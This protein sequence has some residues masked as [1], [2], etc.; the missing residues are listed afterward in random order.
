MILDVLRRGVAQLTKIRHP[1]VLT[2]QHPL[3]ES[4]ESLAFATEL[5]FAS[6]ANIL[7]QTTNMPQPTNLTD[8]KL[9]DV[10]IKYGLLQVSEGLAFLH[11]DVK[12][13]HKNITPENIIVNEFGVWKIFGLDFCVHNTSPPNSEPFYPFEEYSPTVPSVSQPNLDYL[14]P[15]C[16]IVQKHTTASDIFSLGMVAYSLYSHRGQTIIPVKDLQQFK[17]RVT[18]LKNLNI[19]KLQNVPEGLRE[20]IK[21]MLSYTPELRPDAH[22]FV[23]VCCNILN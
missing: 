6:L 17:N 7:G 2:V 14:A 18:Q 1:Q 13:L 4:R 16:I 19:N 20:Y 3:E 23:K 21:L 22:Q 10:E 9:Y 12:L 11:N 15:E 8:Y 5:V